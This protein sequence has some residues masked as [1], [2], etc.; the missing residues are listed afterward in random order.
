[1]HQNEISENTVGPAR[2]VHSIGRRAE[3]MNLRVLC[4]SAL[5]WSS[6]RQSRQR[7]KHRVVKS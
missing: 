5:K 2:E 6:E 3:L 7:M 4:A 1:M